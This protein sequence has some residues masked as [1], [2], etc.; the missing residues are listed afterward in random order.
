M[1]INI[2]IRVPDGVVIAADSLATS[3]MSVKANVTVPPVKCGACGSDVSGQ[4]VQMPPFGVPGNSTPLASKLFYVG[5]F[6][7]TFF[8]TSSLNG[9][10]IFNHVMVFRTTIFRPDMQLGDLADGLAAQLSAAVAADKNLK[11]TGPGTTIVGF[12]VSGYDDA[13]VD[14]GRTTV[15]TIAADAKPSR[16]DQKREYGI[17]VT[18]QQTVVGKLFAAVGGTPSPQ[19][20]FTNMTLPDAIDYA[21]FLVQTTSDYER[22][23]EMVP[24]VGGPTEIALVTKWI[25]F[26]WID[27]KRLLG[28]DS[29][30]LNVGK[31]SHE[32]SHIRRD[33]PEI[34]RSARTPRS[35]DTPH[36]PDAP[37]AS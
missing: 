17:T 34:I 37:A 33:L 20:N 22:F 30:R 5:D 32:I 9:R 11:K 24:T 6:A 29:T 19:P 10:S 3:L 13:D 36:G 35:P 21:R 28:D 8:G 7:V 31:I 18:G 2:S 27:R 23:A 16:Q 12:Q 15:V 4:V 1:T 14:V 25:G 26:R